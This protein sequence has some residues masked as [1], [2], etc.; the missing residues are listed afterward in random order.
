MESI[1]R[2]TGKI[3]VI[4]AAASGIGRASAILIVEQ[5]GTV[6]AIDTD[7]K[8]LEDMSSEC[9]I[10]KGK[11]STHCIDATNEEVVTKT[12]SEI[13]KTNKTIDIL[14]NAI[15]GSTIISNPKARVDE[16]SLND[17]KGIL[18]FNLDSMFIFTNAIVPLMKRQ[19]GGKIVNL[20]SI[21]GRGFSDVSSSA[22]AAAKGGVIAF[23]KKTARELG[24][25][26][27]TVNAIA[28]NTT[29]SER[30]RPRWE[31]QSPQDQVEQIEKIPLRRMAEP[32]DQAKVI[33]FLASTDADYV[34][35]QTIDV[36][37]GLV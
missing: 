33:C 13:L 9:S 11:L 5:G 7:D 4:T 15:G 24:P 18:N 2:F 35:G 25:F 12:I 22:Y 28:P 10:L 14:I 3:A 16:L 34:T 23:T 8:R 19:G 20:A 17:W 30:I 6:I 27:I 29:L 21:A 37:G 31:Q 36:S 26:G 32:I 1:M